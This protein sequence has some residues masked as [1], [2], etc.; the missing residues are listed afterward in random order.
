MLIIVYF[1][2]S[3]GLKPKNNY[4]DIINFLVLLIIN[5]IS[6]YGLEE[7]IY[8]GCAF[9]GL[10]KTKLNYVQI[11]I[12]QSLMFAFSH[13]G[14]FGHNINSLPYYILFGYLFGKIYVTSNSLTPGIL[15]HGIFNMY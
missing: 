7:I 14:G 15:L 10:S 1:L 8:R 6:N 13:L 9:N 3:I 12:I 2:F 4:Y 11:N 5:F